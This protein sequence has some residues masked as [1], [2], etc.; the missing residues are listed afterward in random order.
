VYDAVRTAR[1]FALCKAHA[2]PGSG[3]VAADLV[4]RILDEQMDDGGYAAPADF[5]RGARVSH[6]LDALAVMEH[7]A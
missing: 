4:A 5:S 6:T 2:L 3:L 1:V 7:F